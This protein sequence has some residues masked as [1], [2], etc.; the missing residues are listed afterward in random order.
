M[1]F[2][3][4]VPISRSQDD[5]LGFKSFV[6]LLR[7]ALYNT[8]TPFVYGV[9]GDWGVGKTSILNLLKNQLETD[10]ELGKNCYVPIWFN[11]WEYENEANIL[12]PLIYAIKSDY[13]DRLQDL[14]DKENFWS[15]FKKLTTSA[16]I[17]FSDLGLRVVTKKLTDEA[18]SISDVKDMLNLIEQEGDKLGNLLNTW[19]D[20][21]RLMQES[22]TSL[23]DMY[24]KGLCSSQKYKN[25][26]ED[27][28]KVRFVIL[29]D[30]LDRC[31]P[32]TTIA[33]LERIKNHLMIKN[34]IFVLGL[35]AQVIY[36]GIRVKYQGLEIDGRQYLEKILNYSFY[37]PEPEKVVEFVK[38]RF[39]KLAGNEFTNCKEYFDEFGQ[40]I[41]KCHFTNPRKVK[42]ILNCYLFFL[43]KYEI[44]QYHNSNIIRLIIFAEYFPQIFQLFL[45]KSEESI[46]AL[47]LS[48]KKI[49]EKDFKIEAFEKDY[50][51]DIKSL[52][53]RLS[54]MQELFALNFD[55]VSKKNSVAQHVIDVFQIIRLI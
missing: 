18:L 30:D 47:Y 17:A 6:D 11:A 25:I 27:S 20:N 4:D 37:V 8:E 5:L 32:E 42:R 33:I 49:G 39:E 45:K 34:C 26:K 31:L 23:F 21:V 3:P 40:V 2:L 10:L 41:Q 13:Q 53:Q 24:A 48:L 50:G 16:I 29:I 52:Y 35:N 36:Q 51:V 28:S 1:R 15:S 19:A 54:Q 43:S 7:N 14:E 44:Q 9:I 46:Q 55:T 22:F 38:D 12:Y